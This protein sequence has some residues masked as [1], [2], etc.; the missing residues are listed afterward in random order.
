MTFAIVSRKNA[1]S[2]ISDGKDDEKKK[3]SARTLVQLVSCYNGF[4]LLLAIPFLY[5]YY[6]LF[7]WFILSQFKYATYF[8]VFLIVVSFLFAICHGSALPTAMYIFG[9]LTNLFANYDITL[10]VFDNVTGT[11]ST[12]YADF[13]FLENSTGNPLTIEEAVFN[14][15]VGP[16]VLATEENFTDFLLLSSEAFGLNVTELNETIMIFSCVVFAYG[17]DQTPP[18]TG[19]DVFRLATSG[20]LR[21]TATNGSC[22]CLQPSFTS[23]SEDTRCLTAEQFIFGVRIGDGVIWQIY[24]FIFIAVGVFITAYFQISLIQMAAERQVNR[25]RKLYYENLLKQDMGWFD[26][27]PSGELATRLNE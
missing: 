19:Y 10:Q 18:V 13:T 12:A 23:F 1:K 3:P 27:N 9:D 26:C 20:D 5:R 6:H 21:L 25:I 15:T 24:Y 17:A 11:F 4:W 2:S 8:D 16:A 14:T 7:H 22:Q